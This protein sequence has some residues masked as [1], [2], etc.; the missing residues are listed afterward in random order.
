MKLPNVYIGTSPQ[1]G[2]MASDKSKRWFFYLMHKQG[3]VDHH[4]WLFLHHYPTSIKEIT[5]EQLLQIVQ[6][7]HG[8][9]DA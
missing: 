8:I 6:Q 9:K 5:E 2:E 4:R 7:L 3:I 1:T